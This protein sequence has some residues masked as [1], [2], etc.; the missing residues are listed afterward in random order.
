[1]ECRGADTEDEFNRQRDKIISAIST[2]DADIVGLM[3]IENYFVDDQ[4][5]NPVDVP[6]DDLVAGLNT[7]LGSDIY[8]YIKTGHI[9]SDAI[10]VAII[11]KTATVTPFGNYAILDS[12]VDP[13]FLDEYNRPTLAQSLMDNTNG[14]V[15]TV[16]VN[17]L[18]SKG[19]DCNDIGDPDTGDGAGN[20]NLTRLYASQALVDWLAS[21]PTGSGNNNY[22]I[23]GDLN[24]YDKEDPID[25]V[26]AGSDD[27][28]GTNDD[29]TDLIHHYL[30]ENA[31]T[32]VFD[33]QIG[34]LDHA[35]TNM[36]PLS[37][38]TGTTVWHINAD[39]PDLIDY[40]MT[41]KLDAQDALYEPDPFRSSD[42]DPVIVGLTVAD[43]IAPTIEITVTPD[44]IWPPT[45]KYVDVVATVIVSDNFDQNPTVT[46]LSVTS[47]E[48]DNGEDDGNTVDDIVI[49]DDYH[50]QLRAERSDLGNGRIYTITYL[51]SDA[52]GNETIQS[53]TV[54][55]PISMG[56]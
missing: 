22:L 45:H 42:H 8:S 11:Y 31:Y 10:K 19:S 32:Y 2:L 12:S 13:R 7:A 37:S 21:D 20:C 53:A 40:D 48:L 26:L 35:L 29:Y 15:F 46:L 55:V 33:G 14:G 9:G 6:V 56:N 30:G 54:L 44:L 5:E 38:V 4:E 52:N 41:F 50:F 23:I 24:S 28:L 25:A 1:M 27:V 47:N 49:I 16:A 39:E 18:K 43:N 34:Y 3:E 36:D 51:V 17:H